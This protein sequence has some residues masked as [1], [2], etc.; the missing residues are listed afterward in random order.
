MNHTPFNAL[1]EGQKY[2][3]YWTNTV[4]EQFATTLT[5][6]A[7]R[8]VGPGPRRVIVATAENGEAHF[9]SE[10]SAAGIVFFPA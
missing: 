10:S 6:E 1:I 4:G 5:I 9:Y 8:F 2:A 7:V 3:A